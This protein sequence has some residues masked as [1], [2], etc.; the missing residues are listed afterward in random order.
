LLI[1]PTIIV[2]VGRLAAELA[3][4]EPL[5]LALAVALVVPLAAGEE[6]LLLPDEHAAT[7]SAV[8][9][10]AAMAAREPRLRLILCIGATPLLRF[11]GK[12]KRVR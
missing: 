7:V 1:P 5:A 6:V 2:T 10:A 3:A 11:E 8:A 12:E 9:Q 4:A